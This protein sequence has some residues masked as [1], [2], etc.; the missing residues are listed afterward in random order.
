MVSG[1]IPDLGQQLAEV[2]ATGDV[3]PDPV[4]Q[5]ARPVPA[6]GARQVTL[7]VGGR[8]DIDFDEADVR[9]VQVRERPVAVDERVLGG[10]SVLAH[11]RDLLYVGG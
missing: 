6:D 2:L 5:L 1:P 3:A 9:V 11:V 7:L 4:G 10:V 8:V